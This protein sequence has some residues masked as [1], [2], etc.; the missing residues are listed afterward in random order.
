MG[1]TPL[2]LQALGRQSGPLLRPRPLA[3]LTPLAGG[4]T[5]ASPSVLSPPCLLFSE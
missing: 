4:G 1:R 3:S 2:P 5:T